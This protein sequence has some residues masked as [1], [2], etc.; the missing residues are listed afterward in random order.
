MIR[1]GILGTAAIARL[2][3]GEP[4]KHASIVGIASRDVT[5]AGDFAK[6]YGIPR[7][8]PTYDALI[9]DEEIDAVYIPLPP[10][11]H[12][13]YTIKAA[14]AGKHVLVRKACGSVIGRDRTD[15]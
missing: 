3:F 2:F 8:F 7:V 15:D 6:H 11:L 10:H 13:A 5:R 12:C 14:E 1:I 4:L 9:A